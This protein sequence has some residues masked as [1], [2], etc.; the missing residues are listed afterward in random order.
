MD[1]LEIATCPLATASIVLS[2]KWDLI[3]I[4]NLLDGEKHFSELKSLI[5]QG[6]ERPMTASSLSR[7]LKKLEK[8]GIVIRSVDTSSRNVEITYALTNKGADLKDVIN[9]L[10]KWGQKYP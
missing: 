9:S 3:V 7:I 8:E 4:Y 10:K 6:L 1:Q 5:S 2:S